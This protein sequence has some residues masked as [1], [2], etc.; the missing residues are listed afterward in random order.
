MN[1]S[2]LRTTP[3]IAALL[4]SLSF[5]A[6]AEEQVDPTVLALRNLE[7]SVAGN[8]LDQ[9]ESQLRALQ[10]SIPGDTRLEQSQRV[11]SAAYVRQGESALQA[12]NLAAAEQALSKAQRIMPAGNKQA[13][14]LAAAIQT[15]KEKQQ[16]AA[17]AQAAQQ[18]AKAKAQ[19]EAEAAAARQQKQLAERKAAEA[20]KAAEAAKPKAPVAKLIDPN[21]ASSTI[22]M[23]MLD[24][25]DMDSLRNLLEQVAEEVVAFNC[26]VQL[27]VRQ[28]KD[29]PRVAAILSARVKKIDPGF[30][31]QI[32]PV[33][34]PAND[35]QL[36]LSPRS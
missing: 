2:I 30:D 15:T 11:I 17:Q 7:S 28:S 3:A 32:E 27:D 8:Q 36:V 31:L 19:A 4:L 6:S 25:Q 12:G 34:N 33:I 26:Q 18:A 35:P 16:A 24:T 9:A 21:K 13:G 23:P 1:S 20:K 5:G 22:A 14:A 10:Q 29:Y